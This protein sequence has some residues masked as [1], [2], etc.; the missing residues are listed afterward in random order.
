MSD[1]TDPSEKKVISAEER[2]A[3]FQAVDNVN[4][5][6]DELL[7]RLD[8]L[9]A[10]KQIKLKEIADLIGHGPFNYKGKVLSLRYGLGRGKSKKFSL[11]EQK[12]IQAEEI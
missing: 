5:R 12:I 2:R 6:E 10:E 1:I 4:A 8:E 7:L 3:L 11:M 9:K